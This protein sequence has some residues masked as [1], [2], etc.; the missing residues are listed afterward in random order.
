[1]ATGSY[2]KTG[3]QGNLGSYDVSQG[4]MQSIYKTIFARYA[5]NYPSIQFPR[6]AILGGQPAAGKSSVAKRIMPSF[7]SAAM[8]VHID[9]DELRQF[10]PQYQT[11]YNTDPLN[12]GTHTHSAAGE[13]TVMLLHDAKTAKNDILYEITLRSV[14]W[15]KLE[16]ERFKDDGYAVD[17]HVLAVHES[18]SRLGLFQRFENAVKEGKVPRFVPLAVHDAAYQNLPG[19]VDYLE[20]TCFLDTVTVNN[21]KGDILYNRE[22][23]QGDPAAMKAILDERNRAWTLMESLEH[24]HDWETVITMAANRPDGPLKDPTYMTEIQQSAL[25]MLQY[26]QIRLPKPA[27]EQD[28]ANGPVPNI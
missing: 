22:D 20:N 11:I 4:E 23:Q 3:S 26:P 1:M 14:D 8:P 25:L 27:E 28:L 13:W 5:Q 24:Q 2:S 15:T 12:M 21:R 16:I 10:H 19:N 17:L 18:I 6:I 9:L 7:S